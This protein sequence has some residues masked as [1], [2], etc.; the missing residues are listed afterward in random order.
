MPRGPSFTP[1]GLP[2]IS[3]VTS[4][5][6]ELGNVVCLKLTG[7]IDESLDAAAIFRDLPANVVLDLQGIKRITSFG[8]RQWSDAMKML[9][10]NVQHLYLLRAPSCFIDQLNMVLNFGGRAEVITATA[11]YFCEKCQEERAVPIDVLGEHALLLSGA[12]PAAPCPTCNTPMARS[13]PP[14]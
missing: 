5:R 10:S 12:A 6:I 3:A 13:S 11:L 9:K 2:V 14:P 8:V 4:E 1:A 7:I